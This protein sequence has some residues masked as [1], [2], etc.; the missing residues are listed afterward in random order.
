MNLRYFEIFHIPRTENARTDILFELTTIAYSS[1]GR[2]FVECLEQ[3]SIDKIEKVLQL[4]AEPSW[5]E[6]IIRYLSDGVLSEDPAKAKRTRWIASQ[7]VMVDGCLY[8]RS[9]SLFLLKCLG[10]TDA[11]YVLRK[12]HEEICGSYLGGKS[13]AY[14]I[15]QQGYYWPTMKKDAVDLVR[16]W[17]PCQKY[18][19]IQHQPASQL[20]S[21]VAP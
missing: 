20:M 16:R 4:T 3:S 10:L 21:I 6:L 18:A 17:K 12:V 5:M 9:F 11:D 7:C 15:L 2:T 13:L 1:L 19:N 8:K 14:K